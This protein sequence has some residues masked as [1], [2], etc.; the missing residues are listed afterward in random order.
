MPKKRESDARERILSA[1]YE[2]FSQR[3]IRGV[4]V[5]ELINRSGVANATFYRHFP[6]K[7]DLVRAFLER[8]EELWTLGTIVAQAASRQVSPKG[9]LLA[10][11][12][13]FDEW[14]QRP[15]F[16]GDP[17]ITILLEM[18][19]SHPLGQAA[20][21]HLDTVRGVV[22]RLAVQAGLRNPDA[23]AHSW[24]ILMKGAIITAR[25]GDLLS[26]QR[27]REMGQSLIH[28]YEAAV[29]YHDHVRVRQNVDARR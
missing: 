9:Q 10:I 13:I 12:D 3:G 7:D 19:P 28:R 4:G 25:M 15:D 24:H 1:A 16:E 23:F 8:R 27:A 22:Q 17:F 2:L 18:G 29:P 20:V 11:F 14:F 21:E 26:A 6:S 5:D